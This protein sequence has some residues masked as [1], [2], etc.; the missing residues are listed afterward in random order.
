MEGENINKVSIIKDGKYS[1]EKLKRD[2]SVGIGSNEIS[3]ERSG[4]NTLRSYVTFE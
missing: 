2:R 3:R 1:G 4:R